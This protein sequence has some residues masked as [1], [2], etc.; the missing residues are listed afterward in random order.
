MFLINVKEEKRRLRARCKKL[1]ESC[2]P[3]VKARLDKA[4]TEKVLG[5]E[6]YKACETLFI[7][8]SSPIECETR[9]IIADALQRGKRVAVPR[10]AD[11]SGKMDFYYIRSFDDLSRGTFGLE[12]PDPQTCERVTDLSSGFCIVPGLCFDLEGY[13]V[14][15]GKGYYDRFLDE[16]GGVTAGI[17]YTK[18][19]E[20]QLPRGAFD[21]H[22]DILVTER[23]INRN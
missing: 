17:C 23:F 8:V 18:F 20:K 16:F 21:R 3:E 7:F 13:R 15:F 19:T 9:Q 2:P 5:M 11:R 12:E 1:R 14:G 4:L 22:T 6:E 10:C